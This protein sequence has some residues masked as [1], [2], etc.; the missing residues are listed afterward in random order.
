MI[1][2]LFGSN[3]PI[4]RVHQRR[5]PA[6]R[7]RSRA[8][9]A[10]GTHAALSAEDEALLAEVMAEPMDF[11]DSP[12]FRKPG[13]E[14]A[15]YEKPDP[16]RR[17]D[18]TWYRPLMDDL[19]GRERKERQ[20]R[21]G[22]VL[23]TAAQERVIFLQYNYARFR[24]RQIQDAMGG[25]TPTVEEAREMLRCHRT[26]RRYREQISEINL[27]LVLAMARRVRLGES[28]FPDLIGEGNMA[29][30]RSVDK[31]DCGRGFKFS[32]YACR[33]ILKA[34]SR[35]GIKLVKHRQRFPSEFD[36]EFERSNHLET[37]REQ[38]ARDSAAEVRF[39]VE[40]DR[41]ELSDVER[42]VIEHRFGL[43]APQGAPALTLEQVGQMIGVTKERVRQIQ[44][45]ALE[46]LRLALE[47]VRGEPLPPAMRN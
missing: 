5:R 34:F 12:E 14:A 47:E 46:K 25:R 19:G 45:K 28:D 8:T 21:N 38:H 32:T 39:L 9:A 6:V 44:N 1:D 3:S 11:M 13:A 41:A 42:K 26:A 30:M 36:P 15:I 2:S 33:A 40:S 7:E 23:L 31:F 18:V 10:R 20:A 17:P 27:A 35:F 4:D 24:V 22:S 37:V 29:L 16:I 43:V